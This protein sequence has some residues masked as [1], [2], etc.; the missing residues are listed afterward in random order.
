M[1]TR[2]RTLEQTVATIRSHH[3]PGAIHRASDQHRP[4]VLP[5]GFPALDEALAGGFPL[6]R[7]S[8][9]AGYGTAGQF[10]VAAST[11]AQAQRLERMVACYVDTGATVDLEALVH[12]GVRL[13][14]LAILRPHDFIHALAMTGDLLQSG[15]FAAVAF[16]RLDDQHLL[17][18]PEALQALERA[19][20]S[21]VPL[22][23][24]SLATLLWITTLAWPEAPPQELPL[25]AL[26]SVRLAFRR[27]AW[28]MR[29]PCVA[30]FE[31]RVTVLKNKQGPAG[32][33][34]TLRFPVGAPP[35]RGFAA[36]CRA[37][38]P[39]PRP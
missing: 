23:S 22:L 34:V 9:L 7:F 19:L 26:A 36:S 5:T 4:T 39:A 24:R 17:A 16:D 18:N 14:L 35:W 37:H 2:Q 38:A 12:C 28:L 1:C 8:E 32:H 15:S 21:W 11:L 3:G 33:S 31:S 10:T 6:G 25:D 30:G 20:R 13:D 27:Q 29:G